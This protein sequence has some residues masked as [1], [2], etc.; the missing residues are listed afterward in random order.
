MADLCAA[1]ESTFTYPQ[2]R[3][4][5]F[6]VARSGTS[7]LTTSLRSHPEI[8]CHG[9]ALLPRHFHRHVRG[10]ARAILSPEE[11]EARP[12]AALHRLFACNDGHRVVGCK[13]FRGHSKS[14]Q[15]DILRDPEI[16]KIVLQ[17]EN[18]LAS[19]SSLQL[20]KSTGKW[21]AQRK[22]VIRE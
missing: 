20:A 13:I 16:A 22:Q 5:I 19:Y 15:G 14:A 7:F 4:V 2:V 17:R 12:L 1:S 18:C 11:I 8:L 3:F 21:N 9:E 10:S 6:S